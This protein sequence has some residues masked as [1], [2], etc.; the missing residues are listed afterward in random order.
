MLCS[1][2]L[3]SIYLLDLVLLI[4]LSLPRLTSSPPLPCTRTLAV[5][6]QPAS[7]PEAVQ[8]TRPFRSTGKIPLLPQHFDH[9]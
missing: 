2:L 5:L 9:V 8:C 4:S 3:P 1:Y 7:S 6:P